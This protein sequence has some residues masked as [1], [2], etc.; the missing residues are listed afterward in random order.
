[1][2]EAIRLYDTEN[3]TLFGK[4]GTGD[5]NGKNVLGWF[6]GYLEKD[7]RVYYFATNIQNTAQADGAGAARLT[8][9]ALA[10]LGLF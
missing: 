1:V 4:T 6:V 3:G 9:A 2:K 10:Q 5:K 8:L 7:G